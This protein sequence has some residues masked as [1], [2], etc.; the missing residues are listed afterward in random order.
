MPVKENCDDSHGI[1]RRFSAPVDSPNIHE[2]KKEDEES[3]QAAAI[4]A[5]DTPPKK[6]WTKLAVLEREI[7]KVEKEQD[8]VQEAMEKR[9]PHHGMSDHVSDALE[10]GL[11]M[12]PRECG[13]F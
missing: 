6:P 4:A 12:T 3:E 11:A 1:Y 2:K 5:A 7:R 8:E 10:T 13:F 9:V